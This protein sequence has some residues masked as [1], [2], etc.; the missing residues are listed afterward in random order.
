MADTVITDAG[1]RAV[2]S[3]SDIYIIESGRRGHGRLVGRI[4]P[5]GDRRFYYRYSGPGGKRVMLR[6]GPYDAKGDGIKKFTV[7]Q[8]RSRANALTALYLLGKQDL[9]GHFE[10]QQADNVQ[11]EADAREAAEAEREAARAAKQAA[12]ELAEQRISVRRL[13]AQ[14]QLA[15]LKSHT[16]GDGKRIGRKDGGQWVLDSFERRLFPKLGEM[17][18]ADVRRAH[19]LEILDACKAEGHLRTANVLLADMKQMFGFAANRDLVLRN[20]LEGIKRASVGGKDV[21]RN[22]VLNDGEIRHLARLVPLASLGPRTAAGIWLILATGCRVG[23]LMG[24]EWQHVDTVARTFYLPDTKNQ[25]D[26]TIHL[27]GFALRQFEALAALKEAGPDGA[28]LQWVFPNREGTGPVC[29][30]SFG[31]QLADRQRLPEKRLRNRAK[32][33]GALGLVGGGWTAHDLRRTA[34]TIMAGLGISTDVI[35]ECLNHKLQSK[36]ARVYIHDRRL[37][38]QAIAFDALGERL[39]SLTTA[40]PASG[41]VSSIGGKRKAA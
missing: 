37:T 5:A 18:V 6:I 40:K 35:D 21:E 19:L 12:K 36:V 25:R 24:A 13:F 3:A 15:E 34:A 23:E 41:N 17:A 7:L 9:R 32:N 33:T 31:K 4:T 14:W 20:P 8:A 27:S 30:K 1:M 11:A 29:I 26:H 16:R 2:P 22:R 38:Q 28:T 10:Q 39:E